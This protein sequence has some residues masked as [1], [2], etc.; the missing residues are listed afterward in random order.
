MGIQDN[1]L[2]N[3]NVNFLNK[4]SL[5]KD[6]TIDYDNIAIIA[7]NK[8]L[9]ILLNSTESCGIIFSKLSYKS[10]S[11][12]KNQ[13]IFTELFKLFNKNKVIDSLSFI[14]YL[15][16]NNLLEKS[17]GSKYLADLFN[18]Y[19]NDDYLENY[20]KIVLENSNRL[21]LKSVLN[22]LKLNINNHTKSSEI[23]INEIQESL[24][25]IQEIYLDNLVNVGAIT[26]E[27]FEKVDKLSK[28]EYAFTGIS[29]GYQELDKMT[30]GFQQGE[31]TIIAARPSM[32][33]TALALNIALNV[34]TNKLYK[35]PVVF[36]SLEM[37]NDQ[38]AS[39]L[40]AMVA[41]IDLQKIRTGQNINPQEWSRLEQYKQISN[42][43]T[44]Y[45]DD[46]PGL[47]VLQLELK[48][49]KIKSQ[50]KELGLVIIDYLQLLTISNY[51]DSRQQEISKISRQLKTIARKLDIAIICLSQLSRRV[52]SREDKRP[53]MSDLRD[54]GSIEQDADLVMLLYRASYYQSYQNDPN[55]ESDN[56]NHNNDNVEV[57][58][59]KNRNGP[60]G[61]INLI[62]AKRY[63]LFVKR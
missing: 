4:G 10:F 17:G 35:K 32:G 56:T 57:I 38:L 25:S 49:K 26:K 45:F 15:K 63:G 14:N 58:L 1:E 40:A 22:Y 55:M 52:E 43:L 2:I 9:S 36:F 5:V 51:R 48:L 6:N 19:L 41:R 46:S 28:D 53:I 50:N 30:T 12:S 20:L 21:H 42:T 27:V 37:P 11:L 44:L 39:R 16:N 23:L 31:L 3:N 54:S 59:A 8:I 47:T 34:S 18:D 7:E 60:T 33:K 62:F 13:T 61:K 29:S 24:E